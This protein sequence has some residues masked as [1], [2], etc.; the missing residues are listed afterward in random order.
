MTYS[1]KTIS[2]TLLLSLLLSSCAMVKKHV[3]KPTVDYQDYKLTSV[4]LQDASVDFHLKLNNPNPVR[5]PIKNISYTLRLHNKNLLQG[6]IKPKTDIPANGSTQLTIPAR[7]NYQDVIGG[8][9]GLLDQHAISYELKGDIDLGLIKLPYN[10]AGTI[11]LP[12][13]P[14]IKLDNIKLASVNLSGIELKLKLR[15]KNRNNFPIKIDKLGFDLKL[16]QQ[17][18]VRAE[19]SQT[20]TLKANTDTPLELKLKLGFS[21]VQKVLSQLKAGGEMPVSLNGVFNLPA[22]KGTPPSI[23]FSWNGKV[24]VLN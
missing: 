4:S 12:R 9:K 14:E 8:I 13:L 16:S 22:G 24:P 21:Q 10:T 23:P 19:T 2:F 7:I 17:A 6:K 15:A 11:P 1:I 20:D 18:L 5:I 3:R